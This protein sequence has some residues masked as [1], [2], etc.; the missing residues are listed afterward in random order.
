MSALSSQRLERFYDKVAFL[1]KGRILML[2]T[3]KRLM[4]SLQT[5]VRV[6][7]TLAFPINLDFLKEIDEIKYQKILETEGNNFLIELLLKPKSFNESTR[8][9]A[10]IINIIASHNGMLLN[11]NIKNPNLGDIFIKLGGG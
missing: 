8:I 9:L 4:D 10:K 11:F 5:F 2:D 6:E 1:D 7:I 3:P